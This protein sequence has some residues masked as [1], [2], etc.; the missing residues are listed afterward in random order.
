M[1]NENFYKEKIQTV[2]FR[3]AVRLY[4]ENIHRYQHEGINYKE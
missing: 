4:V 3:N 1:T 2:P